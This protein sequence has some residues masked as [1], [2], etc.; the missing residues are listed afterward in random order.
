MFVGLGN[1]F[2]QISKARFAVKALAA[3]A[4]VYTF[5]SVA[6]YYPFIIPYTNEFVGDKKM[7]F[8]KFID[9]S[10]DYGQSDSSIAKFVANNA[11][12]KLASPVPDT[13]KYAVVMAQA[14]NNY[15]RNNNPY[16]W[17]QKLKPK[18]LYRYVILLYDIKEEDLIKAGLRQQKK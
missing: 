12:Y 13:G 8:T 5:I 1:L 16:N 2:F 17:Y 11:G 10:I 9:S 6:L 15:L 4:V 18:G 14:V 3:G 7:V